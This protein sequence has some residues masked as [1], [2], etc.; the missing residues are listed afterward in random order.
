MKISFLG[1]ISLNDDY[2]MLNKKGINPFKSLESTLDKSDYVVGNLEC[3]AKGDQGENEL[4][5]PRLTTTVETL[6]Y[7]NSIRLKVACL[8]HNHVYDH[9]EDG[10]IKTINFLK[11]HKIQ[12]LGAGL[13]Q[14]EA[15]NP[16]ILILNNISVGFLNYV[17]IDTNPNLPDNAGIVLNIFDYEKC[18]KNI[19][20]LKHHVNHVVLLLHWGGLVEGGNYPDW[21]QPRIAHALIN[22]GADLIIGHHSHT[23]QPY[24]IFKD[25]YIFYSLG[26][27]CFS[28]ICFGG[29]INRINRSG[30]QAIIIN[31][32]FE[33]SNYTVDYISYENR[34][35]KFI[36]V[37]EYD[38]KYRKGRVL[39]KSRIR[40][41]LIWNIYYFQLKNVKP[42]IS[43]IKRDDQSIN[44][45]LRKIYK[46]VCRRL[47]RN[48]II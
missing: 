6:N 42:F 37:P 4:K 45:K 21:D 17:T 16:L 44:Q 34:L 39:K 10:F 38:V 43:F 7:L 24:E 32:S 13:S 9:L 33:K 11:S 29:E 48:N 23:I 12:Y 20:E 19:Y 22:A 3:M 31:V 41:K 8:A 2:V 25:K 27:F 47:N 14:K 30:K 18:K 40:N 46:S 5:K 35:N 28:D 26:N 36:R 1:D 15:V